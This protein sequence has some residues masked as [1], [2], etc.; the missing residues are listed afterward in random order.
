MNLITLY[1]ISFSFKKGKILLKNQYKN[2]ELNTQIIIQKT[3]TIFLTIW[4]IFLSVS[5][6]L[7]YS[8][9]NF[10]AF[11]SRISSSKSI[12]SI[13]SRVFSYP[14]SGTILINISK[15]CPFLRFCFSISLIWP[16]PTPLSYW[17]CSM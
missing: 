9:P 7:P 3:F 16:L 6:L 15:N 12:S 11:L 13:S 1:F 2:Y 8:L 5:R 17:A 4:A 14:F 10:A